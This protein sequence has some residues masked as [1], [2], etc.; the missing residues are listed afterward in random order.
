MARVTQKNRG[1]PKK[2]GEGDSKKARVIQKKWRGLPKKMERVTQKIGKAYPKNGEGYSK[3]V[4]LSVTRGST[5]WSLLGDNKNCQLGGGRQV[6][7][8]GGGYS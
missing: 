4:Q 5:C 7:I 6:I 3:L 1:L 2:S 8:V